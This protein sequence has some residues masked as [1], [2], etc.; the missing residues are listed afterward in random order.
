MKKLHTP[1]HKLYEQY[2]V[3]QAKQKGGSL[4]AFHGAR[5]QHGYGL[6]SIFRGLFRW[7]MPHLQQGAKVIGKKALQTGVN[8]VQ[9]VLDGEKQKNRKTAVHKRT[10]QALNLPSQN[11]LQTQ[12]EADKKAIKRKGQGTKISSPQGK[13]AKTSQRKKPK[14]K[15]SFW[16]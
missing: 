6:G 4:P 5:F 1:N 13:K 7:A 2:Y 10:K 3:N 12:S 16:K 11:S 8:V 9:D 14:E 15:F